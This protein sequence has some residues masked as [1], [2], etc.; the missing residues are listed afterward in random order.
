MVNVKPK[1]IKELMGNPGKKPI[2]DTVEAR[3]ARRIPTPPSFLSGPADGEW[4]RVVKELDWI[5]ILSPLDYFV[6]AAYCEE[7]GTFIDS[8]MR[9]NELALIDDTGNRGLLV[10]TAYGD[11]RPTPLLAIRQ[12]SATLMLRIATEFGMTPSARSRIEAHNLVDSTKTAEDN[13]DDIGEFL[14]RN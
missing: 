8:T 13:P 1:R 10:R 5:G 6:L 2:R 12:K 4:R 7:V 9:L 14:N 11:Y 3:R